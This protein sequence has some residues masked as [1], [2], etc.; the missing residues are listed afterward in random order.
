MV[1]CQ[2]LTC[3]G[4]CQPVHLRFLYYAQFLMSLVFSSN[5]VVGV[6]YRIRPMMHPHCFKES[7]SS[8][9]FVMRN[10]VVTCRKVIKS[11][12]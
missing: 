2:S 10:V 1:D 4:S 7:G 6:L 3:E 12:P 11:L 9:T 5:N 8:G